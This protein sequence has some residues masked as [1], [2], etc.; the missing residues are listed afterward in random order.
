MRFLTISV[1]CLLLLSACDSGQDKKRKTAPKL[2][3]TYQVNAKPLLL[4]QTVYSLLQAH[5]E[6]TISNQ[7][8]GQL[9]SLPVR[10]GDIVE[11]DAELTRQN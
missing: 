11:K 10:Q 9:I 5:R 6:I 1:A 7:E 3:E 8:P 2:V 4:Q